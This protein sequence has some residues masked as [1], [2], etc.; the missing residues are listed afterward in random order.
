M[1]RLK[2]WLYAIGA[3]VM[4]LVGAWFAGRREGKSAAKHEETSRR[5]EVMKEAHEV[6]DEVRALNDTDMRR[7]LTRWM[8]DP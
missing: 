4:A 3:F 5:L 2:L 7:A 1:T 8:R 6:Q